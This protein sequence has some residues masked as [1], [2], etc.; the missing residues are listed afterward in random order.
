MTSIRSVLAVVLLLS[1]IAAP[2]AAEAQPTR[3]SRVGFLLVRSRSDPQAQLQLDAFWQGLRELGY[4]EGQ[5]IAIE[6]RGGR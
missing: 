2:L 5:N 6:Y 1:A 4:V 3:M